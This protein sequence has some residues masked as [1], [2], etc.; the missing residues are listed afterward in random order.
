MRGIEEDEGRALHEVE[1]HH[2]LPD[3]ELSQLRRA[4]RNDKRRQR[5]GTV[6]GIFAMIG[7]EHLL[8]RR[9]LREGRARPVVMVTQPALVA[10]R[11]LVQALD[12]AIEARIDVV[13]RPCE[14][15]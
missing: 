9:R 3:R 1:L 7:R 8:V 6:R 10:L 2:S 4:F 15:R 11:T 14:C 13:Q 5:P 12:G